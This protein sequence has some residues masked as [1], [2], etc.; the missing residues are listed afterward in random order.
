[1]GMVGTEAEETVEAARQAHL[2][3][4]AEQAPTVLWSTDLELRFTLSVGAGL[5][6]LGLA[7]NEVIGLS[8]FEF[9]RTD[10]PGVPSIAAHLRAL[11]GEPARYEQGWEGRDF[12]CYVEPLRGADGTI[13]GTVGLALDIT[14]RRRTAAE[15]NDERDLLRLLMDLLPDAVYMKDES[16]RF[17]RVNRAAATLYGL[18]DPSQ[19]VGK[20]DFD[21]YPEEVARG[22][23]ADE[24]PA[25]EGGQPLVNRLE[26]QSG[27][28]EAA[29]WTLAT[30]VPLADSAGTV[31]GL[32]GISRDVT[33]VVRAQ[34]AVRRSEARFR[35]LI[36]NATEF[37]TILD[38]HGTVRYESPP[39]ER[40]LGYGT[41]ELVGRNAFDLIH[42]DDRTATWAAFE[43]ALAD[44]TYMP[45]VEFRFRHADG[46]WRWMEST[47]T[48]LLADP[49][50]DGFVVN[51]RDVTE[52]KA[53]EARL[54]HQAFYD[55][56]TDLPNRA[57][58]TERLAAALDPARHGNGRV[59]V[60]LLDLDSFKL[61]N[62][63]RGHAMGD[64]LLVVVGR[65]LREHLP[66]AA[67]LAR[68]GGDEFAI[69][70]ER[71]ADPG[72]PAR[73]AEQL[74]EALRPSFTVEGQ[75]VFVTAAVGVAVRAP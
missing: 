70:L 32:V 23:A 73:L 8:L 22:F 67:L 4:V 37:V 33:D 71:V 53:L 42:P 24:R 59:A 14:E 1:M 21:V 58:F 43:A 55:S 34:E 61:V 52:R 68:L 74:T 44:S 19:A 63:S 39:I 20:T 12:E 28:G 30:K 56:L 72:E 17:T 31:T 7:T 27:T 10:D 40:I 36:A 60:L 45:T 13:T 51:S 69:L 16:G 35:S 25:L 9:F 5:A 38:P 46:S 65:R 49:D 62:D 75:E 15:G 57:L 3:F 11:R 48:N 41:E 26:R 64:A 29:R 54:T 6:T 66:P 47:G 18:D 2:R 50:V